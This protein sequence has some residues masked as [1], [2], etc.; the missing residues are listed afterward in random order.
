MKLETSN[1]LW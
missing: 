1:H